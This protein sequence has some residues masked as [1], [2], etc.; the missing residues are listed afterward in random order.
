[1]S[2]KKKDLLDSDSTS[3]QSDED[4]SE[5]G[6]LSV[7][8]SE[9]NQLR[10][11]V[12]AMRKNMTQKNKDNL[13]NGLGS[14]NSSVVSGV[15]STAS[16]HVIHFE[17]VDIN[18]G[19]V[20][21]G[22]K[23]GDDSAAGLMLTDDNLSPEE[24]KRF[25]RYA[26]VS[27][28][29]FMIGALLYICGAHGDLQWA[30]DVQGLPES[31]DGSASSWQHDRHLASSWQQDADLD[32]QPGLRRFLQMQMDEDQDYNSVMWSDLPPDIQLALMILGHN[33]RTWDGAM[34]SSVE[35]LPWSQLTDAQ[36]DA[37]EIIGY[38]ATEWDWVEEEEADAIAQSD[39]YYAASNGGGDDQVGDDQVGDDQAGDDQA[40]D[41]RVQAGDDQAADDQVG[42]DQAVDDQ[43]GDDQVGDDQ[44]G[45]D[46][47]TA[48]QVF[49]YG[50]GKNDD[51]FP[52]TEAP[53]DEGTDEGT[54]ADTEPATVAP[55]LANVAPVAST[56]P[57]AIDTTPVV[58]TPTPDTTAQVPQYN[59]DGA[60][61]TEAPE[62]VAADTTTPQVIPTLQ[63]AQSPTDLMVWGSFGWEELPPN[64]QKAFEILG[65]DEGTSSLADITCFVSERII[66]RI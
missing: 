21:F 48:A 31:T 37:A 52:A 57:P 22:A 4:G 38:N 15:G 50:Q 7:S 12:K 43:V 9:L 10:E 11:H 30:Q 66:S 39:Q 60:P 1:M 56:T 51:Y 23:G 63:N 28:V 13:R 65:Y 32:Y 54:D 35:E 8:V 33:Q 40:G 16:S 49:D 46:G 26:I 6:H 25:F 34:T 14:S 44:V 19:V 24:H 41:D 47:I 45:D 5:M 53:T 2:G 20:A 59:V 3:F 18:G 58:D 64:A 62:A 27:N 17:E 61:V 55:T 36:R 42:D 29:L